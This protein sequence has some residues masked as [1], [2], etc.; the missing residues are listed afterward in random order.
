MAII[1]LNYLVTVQ[2]IGLY[3]NS[4]V[5]LTRNRYLSQLPVKSTKVAYIIDQQHLSPQL[6]QHHSDAHL[7]YQAYVARCDTNAM[8]DLIRLKYTSLSP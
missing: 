5:S 2:G 1:Y 7:Q 3:C 8:W 6:C 4:V